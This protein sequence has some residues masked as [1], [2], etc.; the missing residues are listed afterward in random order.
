MFFY[1]VITGLLFVIVGLRALF[2]PIEAIAIP[3]SLNGNNTDARNYLRSAGGGVAIVAG[4]VMMAGAFIPLLTLSGA[5]TAVTILG[6]L[7]F[8]RLVSVAL[9]GNPGIV[10]WISGAFELLGLVSGAYWLKF[11][12]S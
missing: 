11:Y 4:G 12:L 8:G 1:L 3:Y 6:G 10:P 2:K 9:D 7:V 5:M